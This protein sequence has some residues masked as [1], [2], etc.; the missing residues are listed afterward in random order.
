[1]KK[2]TK[3]TYLRPASIVIALPRMVL[4]AGSEIDPYD[5]PDELLDIPYDS[6]QEDPDEGTFEAL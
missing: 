3:K 1:M 5:D 2:K 4:L 6:F